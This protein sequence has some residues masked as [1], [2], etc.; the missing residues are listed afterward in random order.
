M[1]KKQRRLQDRD[2]GCCDASDAESNYEI[3]SA[4]GEQGG[5]PECCAICEG[6]FQEPVVTKCKHYFC[7]HCAIR[8]YA[9]DGNCFVCGQDTQGTFNAA[10]DLVKHLKQLK[11]GPAE[12]AEDSGNAGSE[13]GN[14]E[15]VLKE[16]AE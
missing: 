2:A 15:E 4:E 12:N 16:F 8:N 14:E 7:D 13:A 11:Q 9:T 10:F 6:D 1:K 5:F 3:H